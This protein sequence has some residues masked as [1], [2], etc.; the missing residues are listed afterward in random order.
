MLLL[1]F[2]AAAA[3]LVR[4]DMLSVIKEERASLTREFSQVRRSLAHTAARLESIAIGMNAVFET[5]F[6]LVDSEFA[7]FETVYVLDE[8]P[9]FDV[10][11]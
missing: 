7:D 2:V 8:D 5:L 6:D 3:A 1:L 4:D 9:F 11:N 10:Y